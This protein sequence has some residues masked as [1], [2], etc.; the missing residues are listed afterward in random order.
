M[1]TFIFILIVTML[2]TIAVRLLLLSR[3]TKALPERLIGI[4]FLSLALM[5]LFRAGAVATQSQDLDVSHFMHHTG[6]GLFC[7]AT[8]TLF[9]FNWRVFRPAEAWARMLSFGGSA[10][11]VSAYAARMIFGEDQLEIK[12]MLNA[13][14]ILPFLWAFFET[15]RYHGMM[16]KRMRLGFGDPV[17]TNCQAQQNDTSLRVRV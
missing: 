16:R 15:L 11:I 8:V 7:V 10:I 9:F 17:V 12:L 4:F 3:E 13:V 5:M 2:I 6:N 14:R 1:A